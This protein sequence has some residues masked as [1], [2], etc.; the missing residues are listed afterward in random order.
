[1][2]IN[3]DGESIFVNIFG[4]EYEIG[5]CRCANQKL[6]V[7]VRNGDTDEEINIDEKENDVCVL[8]LLLKEVFGEKD[9]VEQRKD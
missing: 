8:Y 1:M 6:Q 3:K 9:E 5:Y 2:K 7:W 4:Y